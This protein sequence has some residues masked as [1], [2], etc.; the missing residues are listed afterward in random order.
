MPPIERRGYRSGTITARG[1]RM[2]HT[3]T[4]EIEL[5]Y[6]VHGADADPVLVLISGGG[7]QLIS[8]PGQ[9][10]DRLVAEGFRV[11]RFD[12]R[13]T[14]LSHRSGGPTDVDGG[15]AM[16]EMADDVM[17][18]LDTLGVPAAHLVGH[19]MG[20]IVAQMAVLGHPQRVLSL[21]LLSTLPGKDRRYVLHA[22]PVIAV[23]PRYPLEQL[24]QLSEQYAQADSNGRYDPQLAW[25]REAAIQAYERGYFPE[26]AIRQW[27]AMLRAPERTELLAAVTVPTL[28]FHGREDGSLHWSAAV[29]IAQA[30]PGSELQI[31]PDM[32]HLI[33]WELWPELLGGI[34]RTTRRGEELA[35]R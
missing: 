15:Y 1:R 30:I 11:V 18:V 14:G 27:S 32:G 21:G 12:N 17:R 29:E 34:A 33:P 20:G 6:E 19:S 26:G 28:V 31:H 5:Y 4:D 8:W 22:D 24:V 25:H 16:E 9:F 7:A 35:A 3:N 13:D 2:P 10:V 23:P